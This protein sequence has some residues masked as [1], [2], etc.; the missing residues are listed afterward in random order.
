MRRRKNIVETIN[1]NPLLKWG[2][3][4]TALAA[5][6]LAAYGIGE[7]GTGSGYRVPTWTELYGEKEITY[8]YVNSTFHDD[9]TKICDL[10]VQHDFD[11]LMSGGILCFRN[12]NMTDQPYDCICY[13]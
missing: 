8:V 3:L 6:L 1:D 9:A 7:T 12:A 2:L 13:K 10:L 4:A 11:S 5:M